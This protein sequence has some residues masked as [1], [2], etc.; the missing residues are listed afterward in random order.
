MRTETKTPPVLKAGIKENE[1]SY[2]WLNGERVKGIEGLEIFEDC[3]QLHQLPG[4]KE[5]QRT[6]LNGILDS[7]LEKCAE[8][9]VCSDWPSLVSAA[10]E[11]FSEQ[12]YCVIKHDRAK[13]DLRQPGE[14]TARSSLEERAVIRNAVR[15]MTAADLWNIHRLGRVRRQRRFI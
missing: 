10:K 1:I 11:F 7:T 12:G 15:V 9:G 3:R 6:A 5:E 13:I 14:L 8:E 2:L 4:I